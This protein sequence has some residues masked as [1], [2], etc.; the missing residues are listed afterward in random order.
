MLNSKINKKKSINI[1]YK[2]SV[3]TI[4]ST[5]AL[6]K[7]KRKTTAEHN[8]QLIILKVSKIDD[9]FSH[10][11]RKKKSCFYMINKRLKLH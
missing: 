11:D 7:K 6:K 1:L 8:V 9:K 5:I 10:K 4:H 3:F 2:F